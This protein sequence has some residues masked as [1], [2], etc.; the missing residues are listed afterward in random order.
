MEG[1]G[2]GKE[3]RKTSDTQTPKGIVVDNVLEHIAVYLI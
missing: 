2:I 3:I 1:I